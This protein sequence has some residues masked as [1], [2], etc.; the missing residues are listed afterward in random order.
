MTPLLTD[1]K[2]VRKLSPATA[3]T[4]PCGAIA[5]NASSTSGK[6]ASSSRKHTTT[7][8]MNAT[9]WLRVA[10]DRHEPMARNAP[11]MSSDPR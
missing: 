3:S 8:R 10:A 4:T 11:A 9:T 6:P 5:R 2:W 1:A 7:V